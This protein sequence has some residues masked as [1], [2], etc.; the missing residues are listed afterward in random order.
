MTSSNLERDF[1][2]LVIYG[3]FPLH[4]FR[5]SQGIQSASLRS[6][7]LFFRETLRYGH[8]G[9]LKIKTISQAFISQAL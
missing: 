8:K 6:R 9:N 4:S 7:H 2:L 1:L 5:V 3:I